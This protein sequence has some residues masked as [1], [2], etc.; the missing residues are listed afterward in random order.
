MP[1]CRASAFLF[2]QGGEVVSPTAEKKMK[3]YWRPRSGARIPRA[4]AHPRKFR[5]AGV[6]AFAALIRLLFHPR[7]GA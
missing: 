6:G 1:G 5:E 7:E 2:M 4:G 3:V